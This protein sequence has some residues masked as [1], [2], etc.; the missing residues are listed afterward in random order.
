MFLFSLP[1]ST[2]I[3]AWVTLAIPV[4][5][6]I[7]GIVLPRIAPYIKERHELKTVAKKEIKDQIK[8]NTE[9]IKT[10]DKKRDNAVSEYNEKLS[11]Y[12]KQL[13]EISKENK[14]QQVVLTKLQS[15]VSNLSDQIKERN[16]KVDNWAER[17]SGLE[18]EV[19]S[20][21][22]MLRTLLNRKGDE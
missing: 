19:K 1:T 3:I 8:K 4:I 7:I 14:E 2:Q 12:S 5:A 15:E 13:T 10:L 6:T 21:G 18:G 20:F 9:D 17:L 11:D 16:N 22:A